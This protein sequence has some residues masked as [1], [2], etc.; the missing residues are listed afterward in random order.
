MM[1]WVEYSGKITRSIPGRPIFMPF[2]I[3]AILRRCEH[4][5]LGVKTRHLVVDDGHADRVGIR[6]MPVRI[7][8]STLRYG[9]IIRPCG[10]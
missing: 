2:N 6:S 9:K 3:S 8:S 7:F 5:G 10:T 4:L 1:P